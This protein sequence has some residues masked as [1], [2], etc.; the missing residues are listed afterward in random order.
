M[1][2]RL[3]KAL[4]TSKYLATLHNQ[5]R[6]LQEQ[7]KSESKYYFGGGQFTVDQ[8]LISFVNTLLKC[9]QNTAVLIDD[10]T[11]PINIPDLDFFFNEILNVYFTASN[12]F[13]TEYNKLKTK[14]S[15]KGLID[16]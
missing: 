5:K 14:R 9:N 12:K 7:Y 8:T 10:H 6:I 4:D 1:D 3:I 11:T 2:E 16:D 13:L 15:V